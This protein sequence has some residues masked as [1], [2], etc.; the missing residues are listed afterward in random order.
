METPQLLKNLRNTAL[1]GIYGL[2]L[3]YHSS[4]RKSE[5]FKT[6]MVAAYMKILSEMVGTSTEEWAMELMDETISKDDISMTTQE[7]L[8]QLT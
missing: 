4:I 1:S 8:V 5:F 6:K 2:A 3:S 7:H